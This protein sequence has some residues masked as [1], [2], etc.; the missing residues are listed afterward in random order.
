MRN[1][2]KTYKR[3]A[4]AGLVLA[5]SGTV[6]GA[7]STDEVSQANELG[8]RV[9]LR[10]QTFTLGR[11]KL[12]KEVTYDYIESVPSTTLVGQALRSQEEDITPLP[13]DFEGYV[14][15]RGRIKS[16]NTIW[17]EIAVNGEPAGYITQNRLEVKPITRTTRVDLPDGLQKRQAL[18]SDTPFYRNLTF[19]SGQEENLPESTEFTVLGV[20]DVAY[21]N[22]PVESVKIET[23]DGTVGWV[24]VSDIVADEGALS[25]LTETTDDHEDLEE[26]E[27]TEYTGEAVTH[28]SLKSDTV[29]YTHPTYLE[30]GRAVTTVSDEQEVEVLD[31]VSDDEV[32]LTY[33]K[34]FTKDGREGYIAVNEHGEATER[35]IADVE[36]INE[37]VHLTAPVVLTSLPVGVSGSRDSGLVNDDV[38]LTA[39]QRVLVEDI[40][41][42]VD[43][44]EDV[45]EFVDAEEDELE[46]A[47]E[48]TED[49]TEEVTEED[50]ELLVEEQEES[51]G[52]V[53]YR[54]VDSDT[55]EDRGYALDSNVRFIDSEDEG[56]F[57]NSVVSDESTDAETSNDEEEV[58]SELAEV[59]RIRDR[60]MES[61]VRDTMSDDEVLDMVESSPTLQGWTVGQ[62]TGNAREYRRP[63]SATSDTTVNFI[64][65]LAPY[66]S[67]V[68]EGGLYPSVM[69]A[70]AILESNSGR[71]GL[72][73]NDNNLF[74]IKGAYNGQSAS[75]R[76]QESNGVQFYGIQA[77]FRKY[78]DLRS[79]MADYVRL[80]NNDNYTRNGVVNAP[81]AFQSLVGLKEAGY[82]T[83]PLYIPK[84]WNIIELYDLTQFD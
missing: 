70:Q 47:E 67:Q 57:G 43:E 83:D 25:S 24:K 38:H 56:D 39:V 32:V 8:N 72:A 7:Y 59:E 45:D 79:G 68:Q 15:V 51:Q 52:S 37:Q 69:I 40:S 3:V 26:A 46:D 58:N 50:G 31:K 63:S 34:I 5:L 13:E 65:R 62:E 29:I 55:G 30:Y 49:V 74:G 75:Y 4:V 64:R 6:Y 48:I 23:E 76:T 12:D 36:E 44:L 73:R 61:D 11:L 66:S 80:L 35:V 77:G 82:A 60:L 17:L 53:Y 2:N 9:E 1:T 18:S 10:D 28:T 19:L 81:S 20:Y 21:Y 78:P 33:Y 41:G 42:S 14:E 16:G 22:N 84:V 54:L 27:D 71:S